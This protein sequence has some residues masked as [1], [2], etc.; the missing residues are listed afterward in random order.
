MKAQALVALCCLLVFFYFSLCCVVVEFCFGSV[1]LRVF[2]AF[3][4]DTTSIAFSKM[5]RI[6]C[7]CCLLVVT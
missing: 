7:R 2:S 5:L 6:W 4:M 1:A 3:F